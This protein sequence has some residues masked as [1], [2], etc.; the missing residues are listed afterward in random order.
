MTMSQ[1]AFSKNEDYTSGEVHWLNINVDLLYW[2]G[3][4]G[5]E[6]DYWE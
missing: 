2:F 6:E 3:I 1:F 5:N 4:D